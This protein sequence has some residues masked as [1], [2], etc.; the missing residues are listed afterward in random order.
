MADPATQ[1]AQGA[2]DAAQSAGNNGQQA[3]GRTFTQEQLDAII[4]DRLTRERDKYKDF[5]T[6]KAS[7]DELQKVKQAQMTETQKLRAQLD[8]ISKEN[9]DLKSRVQTATAERAATKAGALYPDL[10]A[11]K[12]PSDALSDD[13]KLDAAIADIKKAYPAL[14]GKAGGGSADGGA[15]GKTVGNSMNDFI[16]KAAGR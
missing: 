1:G 7:H 10:V 5:D 15:G 2:G 13:K 8:Q 3:G 11:A 4:A 14:F 6:F 12:I 16:R 9:N